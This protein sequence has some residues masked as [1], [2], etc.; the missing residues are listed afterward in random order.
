MEKVDEHMKLCLSSL[1][2]KF[3]HYN[4]VYVIVGKKRDSMKVESIALAGIRET[5]H[6]EEERPD[7]DFDFSFWFSLIVQ[8]G[9]YTVFVFTGSHQL[10]DSFLVP[11]PKMGAAIFVCPYISLSTL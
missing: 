6:T 4:N 2:Q 1:T 8:T 11:T 5:C 7:T 9:V 10:S 3:I